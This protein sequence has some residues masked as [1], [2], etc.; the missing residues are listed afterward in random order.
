MTVIT[1]YTTLQTAVLEYLAREE[2]V[3][4]A[5][6]IP[7]FIQFF[8][9]KMNRNLFVAQM[10]QR[11]TA[12]VNT[13]SSEP[14]F[15]SLPTDFQS[16]RRVRLN[17]VTGKPRLGFLSRTQMDDFR[18]STDNV[19]GQPAY[20]TIFG[21]ELELAPTPGEAYEL[22]MVYRK[23][24]PALADNSTNWLL[25]LAPD[26]YLYGTLLESAPHTRNESRIPI[27]ATGY[28]T[29]LNELNTLGD[30]QS[31]DAGPSSITL[32]GVVV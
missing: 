10:E 24:I 28:S 11:S 32:P 23:N 27:W 9:A 2:D 8:E 18:Y 16:M 26:L 7:T 15:I 1:N 25:T 31:F 21:S 12:T 20:F 6:R 29:A 13:S 22:E 4:L 5:S 17:G 19:P 30:R 14:E 3:T